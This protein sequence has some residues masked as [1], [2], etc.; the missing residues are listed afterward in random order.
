MIRVLLVDDHT[1]FRQ[2]LRQILETEEGIE[3]VGEAKDGAEAVKVALRLEPDVILMD[4]QM[5]GMGGVEATRQISQRHPKS[6]IIILTMHRQDK[7][8]FE[9]IK[10]GAKGYLLKDADS[11]EVITA[12]KRV[13][14]GEAIIDPGLATKMLDEFKRL[15]KLARPQELQELTPQEMEILGLVAEG[16][17]NAEVAARLHLS[18]KTVRNRLTVIYEKLQVN[19]RTQAALLAQKA[20]L[21]KPPAPPE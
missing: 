9:A 12:I 15:E 13:Y 1:L 2:G 8:L 16:V 4:I 19:N 17:S 7:F 21:G 20:G 5:P 18:D 6:Q 3:V 10:S 11:A 14:K